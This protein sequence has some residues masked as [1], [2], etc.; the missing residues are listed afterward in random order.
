MCKATTPM[1]QLIGHNWNSK[2]KPEYDQHT[3]TV[4]HNH[5]DFYTEGYTFYNY[6]NR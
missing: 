1:I 3:V 4:F 6:I 2:K 5:I